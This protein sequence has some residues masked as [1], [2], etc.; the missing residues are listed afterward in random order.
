[1]TLLCWLNSWQLTWHY[2]SL[3]KCGVPERSLW[4]GSS[5]VPWREIRY[6]C[7]KMSSVKIDG[8][9]SSQHSLFKSHETRISQC[10][11]RYS[12]VSEWAL[13]ARDLTMQGTS[14]LNPIMTRTDRFFILRICKRSSNRAVVKRCISGSPIC[15]KIYILYAYTLHN[16]MYD[17][18]M[19]Y[20]DSNR[21]EW[22]MNQAK[23]DCEC[24]INSQRWLRHNVDMTFNSLRPSDANLLR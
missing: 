12:D 23:H 5:S 13:S 24:R 4:A 9:T 14:C 20:Q 15:I 17:D 7:I 10:T 11:M 1:M 22:N 18:I 8:E 6:H 2:S 21:F 19:I 3:S 16:M